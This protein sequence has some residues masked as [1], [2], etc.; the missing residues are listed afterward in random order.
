MRMNS[1]V[2]KKSWE[3]TWQGYS[4]KAATT[5]VVAALANKYHMAFYEGRDGIFNRVD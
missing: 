3:L 1:D 2:K 4:F 5:K